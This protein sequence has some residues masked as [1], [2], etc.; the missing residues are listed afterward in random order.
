[1]WENTK[2]VILK[3]GFEGHERFSPTKTEGEKKKMPSRKTG[4]SKNIPIR[5]YSGRCM[6]ITSVRQC[7]QNANI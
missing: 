6:V 3:L 2:E 7:E 1:M 4:I 5:K